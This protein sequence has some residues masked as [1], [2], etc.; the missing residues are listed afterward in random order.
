MEETVLELA[1]GGA[2]EGGAGVDLHQADQ[3]GVQLGGL[4]GG[5]GLHQPLHHGLADGGLVAGLW[6]GERP[7]VTCEVSV[8]VRQSRRQADCWQKLLL[9]VRSESVRQLSHRVTASWG[10]MVREDSREDKRPATSESRVR[11]VKGPRSPTMLLLTPASGWP[12]SLRRGSTSLA[13]TDR[14]WGV[15]VLESL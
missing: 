12:S 6:R 14:P 7:A 4:Q 11:C 10:V 15:A 5:A 1:A 3:E 9:T 8:S 2:L 13:D